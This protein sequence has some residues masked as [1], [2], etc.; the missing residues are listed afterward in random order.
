MRA[1]NDNPKVQET[2]KKCSG[3]KQ[4]KARML[5]LLLLL[6]TRLPVYEYFVKS[7]ER[8][9]KRLILTKESQQTKGDT[10]DG[11]AVARC[12]GISGGRG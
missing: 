6:A 5:L 8:K 10:E 3:S 11:G 1:A 12:V 7:M 2:V 9:K 4:Q